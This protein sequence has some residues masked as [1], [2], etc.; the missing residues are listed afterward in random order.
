VPIF[1]KLVV[2]TEKHHTVSTHPV[3]GR[4][5]ELLFLLMLDH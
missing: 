4:I 1:H 3:L 5:P 2:Y